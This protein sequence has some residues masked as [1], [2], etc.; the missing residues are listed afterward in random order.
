MKIKDTVISVFF[1]YECNILFLCNKDIVRK[2]TPHVKSLMFK[3]R[4]LLIF[5]RNC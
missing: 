5:S 3:I 4:S 2:K 1:T